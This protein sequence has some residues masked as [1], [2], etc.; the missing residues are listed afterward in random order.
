MIETRYRELRAQGRRLTGTVM[1]YGDT[2]VIPGI[3]VERFASFAFADYLGA[4]ADV[5]LNVMHESD[6]VV[7]T[8]RGGE[9]VLT[10]SP[11]G[12]AMVATLPAGDAFDDVLGMVGDGL[13]GGL[14]VE[15]HALDE[16]RTGRQRIIRKATLPAL[17]IVDEPAYAG[18]AVELRAK[19]RG[20]SGSVPVQPAAHCR[21]TAADVASGPT[22]RGAFAYNLERWASLQA[23][24]A[25]AIQEA[26]AD[27]VAKAREAVAQTPDVLLLRGRRT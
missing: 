1:Q 10:D 5:A 26:V 7:A 12:L 17:G 21:G 19:G 22:G 9:L 8:R 27:E 6:L 16:V 20:I 13:T 18:S 3:G 24:L 23:E 2:A 11:T 4:G 14:S 15:F 25:K